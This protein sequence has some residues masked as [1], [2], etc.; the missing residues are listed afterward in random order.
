[1]RR[2]GDIERIEDRVVAEHPIADLVQDEDLLLVSKLVH[3]GS[4]GD[5]G[6]L[7]V[8]RPARAMPADMWT[9]CV[10]MSRS[11][12]PAMLRVVN[13]LK[14]IFVAGLV[15][16][17]AANAGAA[18][19]G[20]DYGSDEVCAVLASDPEDWVDDQCASAFVRRAEKSPA[21]F[22]QTLSPKEQ[23]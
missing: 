13:H 23:S 8:P 7:R 11:R 9:T 15:A 12:H 16:A 17:F 10:D 5:A 21:A 14:Y 22:R 2:P 4:L 1:V 18:P 3:G 20:A 19:F 6:V